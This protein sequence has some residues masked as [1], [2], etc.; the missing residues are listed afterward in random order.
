MKR[1]EFLSASVKGTA[2]M[3]FLPNFL[4]YAR[5]AGYTLFPIR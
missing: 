1:R 3:A 2:A 5:D 4:H